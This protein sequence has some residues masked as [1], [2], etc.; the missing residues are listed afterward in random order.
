MTTSRMSDDGVDRSRPGSS[1]ACWSHP[2][3]A[4]WMW[5]AARARSPARSSIARIRSR[6][7]GST[8]RGISW[9]EHA[10]TVIDPRVRFVIGDGAAL[11]LD[12]GSVDAVVSGLVLNHVADASVLLAEMHR[13]AVAG[14]TVAA[15]VWD[16]AGRMDMIRRFW[17]A[18][19]VLDPDAAA[20]DQGVRS[21]ICSPGPLRDAFEKADLT[22]VDVQ[23]IDVP[24]AFPRLRRVLGSVPHR[25]RSGPGIRRVAGSR[26]AGDTAVPCS[27]SRC[28]SPTTEASICSPG[29][30][31]SAAA[32]RLGVA[33]SGRRGR[34]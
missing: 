8:R 26:G 5:A 4:G 2:E 24:T 18:A 27:R 15:Y 28:R 21:P 14:G 31:P 10:A 34:P 1:T 6:S 13:V 25:C 3:R 11:P 7:S 22:A 30:G 17:D 32:P 16:Y 19:V 23:P 9:S 29:R 12:D 20:L 33:S